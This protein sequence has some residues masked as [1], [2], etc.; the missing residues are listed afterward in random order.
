MYIFCIIIHTRHLEYPYFIWPLHLKK[1]HGSTCLQLATS[2][3]L[4][5][6]NLPLSVIVF[7]MLWTSESSRFLSSYFIEI[8]SWNIINLTKKKIGKIKW[9]FFLYKQFYCVQFSLQCQTFETSLICS[10]SSIFPRVSGSHP[11]FGKMILSI[12][13]FCINSIIM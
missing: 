8:L 9:C 5:F 11:L 7:S 6:L 3:L 2:K 12:F 4:V 13:F 1:N 10:I